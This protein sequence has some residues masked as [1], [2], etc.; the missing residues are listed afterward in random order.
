[1][2]AD[3]LNLQREL[4]TLDS[5]SVDYVH[6][7]FMDNKFVP[8]IT[9]DAS[10]IRAVKPV[11]KNMKRDIHIMA[12]A[13]Q[14]YF[15]RMDIGEGDI[16]SVHYEACDD[17]HDVLAEI[18][19]RGAKAFIAISPDT[20]VEVI[21]EYIAE[22]DGIL[23]MTVYPGFAGQPIVEGSFEKIKAVRELIDKSGRELI[24]EV[25]GHVSWD[26]CGKMR[27]NGADLFVAGS[28]SVYQKGLELS[29]AV[30]RMTELIR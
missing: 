5:L 30:R 24:L 23:V 7:D 21:Y 22:I 6:L 2:C 12:Y 10:L 26:L 9:L 27:E 28:S 29:E 8:N 17:L 18:R 25:D 15:E 20:S 16:V 1:M 13:P 14:Q 3:M 11:L 4:E 19:A